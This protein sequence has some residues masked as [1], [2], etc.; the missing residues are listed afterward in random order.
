[1]SGR[2]RNQ[3]DNNLLNALAGPADAAGAFDASS[4]LRQRR[5]R[6][7][8]P[9]CLRVAARGIVVCADHRERRKTKNAMEVGKNFP[10]NLYFGKSNA[11]SGA[12]TTPVAAIRLTIKVTATILQAGIG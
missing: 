5:A 1:V 12:F 8:H 4:A 6:Q 2:S 3:P 11:T 7:T 9:G 10:E